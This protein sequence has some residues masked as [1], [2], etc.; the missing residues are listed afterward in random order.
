MN[1]VFN[2]YRR[3]T[4]FDQTVPVIDTIEKNCPSESSGL[5]KDIPQKI[6]IKLSRCELKIT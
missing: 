4:D 2:I 5:A 1:Y 3:S 6:T